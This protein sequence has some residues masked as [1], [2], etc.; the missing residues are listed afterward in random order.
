[1][2]MA[3][4]KMALDSFG[5][6]HRRSRHQVTVAL[7]SHRLHPLASAPSQADSQGQTPLTSQRTGFLFAALVEGISTY[8]QGALRVPSPS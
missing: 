1:M 7:L 3:S 8:F 6:R 4:Y 5:S 2:R